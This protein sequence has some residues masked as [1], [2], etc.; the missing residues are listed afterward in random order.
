MKYLKFSVCIALLLIR[1]ESIAA[2]Q[3]NLEKELKLMQ[4]AYKKYEFLSYNVQYLYAEEKTPHQFIDT[5]LGNYKLHQG[6]YWGKLDNVECV[7]TDSF[8]ISVYDEDKVIMLN[9]S[10]PV[11]MQTNMNWDSVWQQSNRDMKCSIERD[12]GL[13]KI[14]MENLKE[15]SSY[16]RVVFW[17][18]PADYLVQKMQY[19]VRQPIEQS[20][21][22]NTQQ[23]HENDFVIIEVR[24]SNY[25]QTAF[26]RN[27]F[28][29]EKYIERSGKEFKPAKKYNEYTLMVGSPDL[30]N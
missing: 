17:Y 8:F 24:F 4:A 6:K 12:S 7:Q 13:M 21:E 27:I 16:K 28:L 14:T 23:E 26:D 5:V 30:L 15:N 1:V 10:A 29:A 3:L 22:V 19:L 2:Q 20:D 11:W 25:T 9:S 18:N